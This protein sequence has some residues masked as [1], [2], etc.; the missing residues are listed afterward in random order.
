MNE[1]IFNSVHH[2]H[3]PYTI[4]IRQQW[5]TPGVSNCMVLYFKR[6]CYL[7]VG[8]NAWDNE[9]LFVDPFDKS[10]ISGSGGQL[11]LSLAST[12]N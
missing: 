1:P 9:P 7:H 4:A 2:L 5:L 11:P 10:I 3:Q 12:E 6:I 8:Y